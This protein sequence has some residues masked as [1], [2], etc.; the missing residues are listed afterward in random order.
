MNLGKLLRV[1]LVQSFTTDFPNYVFYS[2][3]IHLLYNA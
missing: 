2:Y 3:N 1:R